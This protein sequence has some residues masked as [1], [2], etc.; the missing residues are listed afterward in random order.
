MLS[1]LQ[2]SLNELELR[3]V[4]HLGENKGKFLRGYSGSYWNICSGTGCSWVDGTE[5]LAEVFP[6]YKLEDRA[7]VPVDQVLRG[8]GETVVFHQ[9]GQVEYLSRRFGIHRTT[10]YR[11]VVNTLTPLQVDSAPWPMA[12]FC[13]VNSLETFGEQKKAASRAAHITNLSR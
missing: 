9:S 4:L 11:W 13:R 6:D 3:R 10:A 8:F 7:E 2:Y 5:C 1:R 12:S